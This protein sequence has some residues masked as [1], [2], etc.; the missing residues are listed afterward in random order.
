MSS[1]Q[2]KKRTTT[3]EQWE[4][5]DGTDNESAPLDHHTTGETGPSVRL[6]NRRFIGLGEEVSNTEGEDRAPLGR[7]NSYQHPDEGATTPQAEGTGWL[8]G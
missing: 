6:V 8:L 1:E 3:S 2:T 4:A 7:A 5:R